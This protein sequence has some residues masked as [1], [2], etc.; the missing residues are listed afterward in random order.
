MSTPEKLQR[1]ISPYAARLTGAMRCLCAS[2]RKQLRP[3]GVVTVLIV[4]MWIVRVLA[5]VTMICDLEWQLAVIHCRNTGYP[6]DG[7]GWDDRRRGRESCA[8]LEP[9]WC[10]ARRELG[11]LVR[12]VKTVAVH[13][14]C[15]RAGGTMG[16]R[17]APVCATGN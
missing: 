4:L 17:R 2:V 13:V 3:S 1:A 10:A 5:W 7:D 6:K 11:E 16:R 14:R 15:V 12:P 9:P 8:L